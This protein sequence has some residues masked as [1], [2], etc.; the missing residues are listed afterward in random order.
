MMKT[1]I[2]MM[3]MINIFNE[4][5]ARLVSLCIPLLIL[6]LIYEV[7]ARYAFNAPTT[8]SGDATYFLCSIALVFTLAYTW[9]VGGHVSVDM[10]LVKFPV[11]VQAFLNVF[12]M[13]T[14]FFLCW[15]LIVWAM[16][17]TVIESWRILERS[18]IGFFP[19][20]YPYKTWIL[21]G[22]IML[23]FQGF[24]IFISELYRLIKGKE[25]KIS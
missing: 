15:F 21:I 4:K 14:M 1:V 16:V 18:T 5:I 7:V 11:K 6:S 2:A 25:L 10:I 9:Q 19:P 24:N 8:W 3:K 13:L 23:V 20:I 17:P 22:T 12:F